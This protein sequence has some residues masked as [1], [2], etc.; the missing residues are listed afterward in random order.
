MMTRFPCDGVLV[1][2]PNLVKRR[3][4][5]SLHHNYHI[6]YVSIELSP[7][8]KQFIEL[9]CTNQTPAEIHRDL[10]V[11]GIPEVE[12]VAQH[13]VYYQ[14]QCANSSSWRLDV[15]PFVSAAKFLDKLGRKYQYATNSSGNLHAFAIYIR[16]TVLLIEF[17][18]KV[19]VSLKNAENIFLL[20]VPI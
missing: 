8:A 11:S 12:N 20:H 18:I 7:E 9:R 17:K 2:K 6:P 4:V 15:G 10:K 3:L 1:V 14:W 19:L 16:G 13:Q 5:I